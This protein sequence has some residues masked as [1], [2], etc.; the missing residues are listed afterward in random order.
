MKNLFG[1]L[2]K[3][4]AYSF[5]ENYFSEKFKS[6]NLPFKYQNFDIP[7][8]SELPILLNDKIEN[9]IGFNVTIPY[10]EKI[11]NYLDDVDTIA[12]E[13]G[14]V[15][16]VKIV[17]NTYLKGYNTDCYG[18]EKSLKPLLKPTHKKALILG[19]GGASKAI[20]FVLKKL[21]ISFKEVSRTPNS[22]QF[23]YTDITKNILNEYT[24]IINCT[25]VGTFPNTELAPKIPYLFLTKEHLLFD[26]I[27][28]PK[29]TLFLK[30]G[31]KQGA[32]IKNGLEMLK[33][34]AEKSF[35]IW[36]NK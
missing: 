6:E 2:G 11:V 21:N 27:Y 31:K 16:T 26:L 30:N 7:T 32:T 29:E 33:L 24:I 14:A 3:N 36:M 28:N 22:N 17:D 10:K 20:K 4:I 35:E 1:L 5:S 13:I 15:N 23:S 12:N 34:Q 8:I 18:F 19:T 25:P 9:L